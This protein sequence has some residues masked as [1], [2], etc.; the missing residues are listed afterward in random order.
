MAQHQHKEDSDVIDR[1]ALNSMFGMRDGETYYVVNDDSFDPAKLI[2]YSSI[3]DFVI[4]NLD[5]YAKKSTAYKEYNK[6]MLRVIKSDYNVGAGN[7]AYLDTVHP[8]LDR[9]WHA[10]AYLPHLMIDDEVEEQ[11]RIAKAF[12]LGVACRR[13]WYI[14]IDRETCWAF[15]K[16]DQR[17]PNRMILEEKPVTRPSFYQLFL[18]V[19]EN[20]VV[21]NDIHNQAKHDVTDAYNRIR[22][23]G[24]TT[25][26]LLKQPIVEGFIGDSYTADDIKDLG[27]LY[28]GIYNDGRKPVNILDVI[29]SV[30]TDSYDLS[31]V[32]SLVDNLSDYLNEYCLKMTNDQPGAA[33]ELFDA[34]AKAIGKNF[35]SLSNAPIEFKM[36]IEAYL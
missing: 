29:Y 2:C 6:R 19:D 14:E 25:A 32:S 35:V 30:Y 26:D 20:A 13:M 5:K 3:Y 1:D 18:A 8:H 21:V 12:L 16:K 27:K 33:R 7:T 11:K 31:L 17:L 36:L 23:G 9:R 34:A 22:V 28:F 10:H 15:R 24:I 4:E